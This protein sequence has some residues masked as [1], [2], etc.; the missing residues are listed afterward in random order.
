MTGNLLLFTLF[1]AHHSLMA[2]TGAKRWLVRHLPQ[3]LE[4]T[5]YV[6]VA[7]LLFFATCAL[8]NELPGVVYQTSGLTRVLGYAGQLGGV[9]LT[10]ASVRVLDPRELAGFAD[11]SPSPALEARGPYRIV[12][13]PIY[14]GWVLM[15]FA[16]PD[17]WTTRL[18]FAVISSA[19]LVVA[20]PWEE[21]GMGEVFGTAYGR[22]RD[23]VR[24]R[25]IPGVW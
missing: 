3:A 22:Y 5:T 24:W 7:S 23:Q 2:R 11:P 17:M 4:R 14:L 12:R 13:H 21:R 8:W 9:A 25:L 18:A 16:A 19:Y 15:V 1:A 6:W 20:I 10:A